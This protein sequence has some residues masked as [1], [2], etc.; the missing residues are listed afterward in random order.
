MQWW[1][2]ANS[3][4]A[5]SSTHS[6]DDHTTFRHCQRRPRRRPRRRWQSDHTLPL[7][8]VQL[9]LLMLLLL[10]PRNPLPH[11]ILPI[12]SATKPNS[13][14][15]VLNIP[16]SA[17]QSDIKRA[18]RKAALQHHPDKVPPSERTKAE[19]KFKEIAKAYEWLSDEKKRKLYDA[20]GE[21]SLDANFNPLFHNNNNYNDDG[22][23]SRYHPQGRRDGG[24]TP[25]F[26][27]G[28]TGAAGGGFPGG[29]FFGGGGSGMF[30]GPGMGG[31]VGGDGDFAH[32]VDLNELLRQMMGG[33]MPMG[34]SSSSSSSSSRMRG[35]NSKTG[36]SD[37]SSA[38]GMDREWQYQQQQHQQTQH[39]PRRRK[40]QHKEYIKPVYCSLEDLSRGCIKKLKVSYPPPLDCDKIYHV[41]IQPGWTEGTKIKFPSSRSSNE[42]DVE[43][44]YYP[45]ITFVVR[46]KKHPYLQHDIE[47][48]DLLWKCKLTT[49]QVERGAKLKLPLP[50]GSLL[51]IESKSG[52]RSGEVMRV[53]GRGMLRKTG[54]GGGAGDQKKKKGDV[55]IEFVVER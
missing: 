41:Q 31:G 38:F 13:L 9:L 36:S 19:H 14:Y 10:L 54:E 20:Y 25:T 18:Y 23:N 50:D 40:E 8:L 32:A 53:S 30:G 29:G 42:D 46:E 55:I 16:K 45:P 22:G 5:P 15:S 4:Q 27:F 33:G 2:Q 11:I 34:S 6:H 28:N 43:C 7:L 48:G 21:K 1:P 49:R 47:N 17:S 35:M 51:E 44:H 52:T 24:G 3:R 39:R 37:S 26:H 12:V